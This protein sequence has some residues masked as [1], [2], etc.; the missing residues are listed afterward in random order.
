M[1]DLAAQAEIIGNA[2]GVQQ[3]HEAELE[4]DDGR[5]IIHESREL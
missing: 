2:R 1:N 3:D 5:S 4:D